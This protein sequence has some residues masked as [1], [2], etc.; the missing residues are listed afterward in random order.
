M[1]NACGNLGKNRYGLI[2]DFYWPYP[3][4]RKEKEIHTIIYGDGDRVW[5]TRQHKKEEVRYVVERIRKAC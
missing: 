3:E 2:G 5:I 1:K 4:N